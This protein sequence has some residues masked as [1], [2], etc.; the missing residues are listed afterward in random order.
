MHIL[1]PKMY[2]FDHWKAQEMKGG[3]IKYIYRFKQSHFA[4]KKITFYHRKYTHRTTKNAHIL[5]L[6]TPRNARRDILNI[7][8]GSNNHI[9][10]KKS[11]FTT[12]RQSHFDA[13]K[14]HFTT[15]NKHILPPKMYTFDHGKAHY[16]QRVIY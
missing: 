4:A 5:P 7:Y 11:H 1:P 15:E 2:T 16:M 13:K 8:I 10:N 12:E 9:L 14:S 3:Y 6:E